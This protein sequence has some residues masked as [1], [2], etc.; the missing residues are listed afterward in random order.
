MELRAVDRR[1][2]HDRLRV[3]LAPLRLTDSLPGH[4]TVVVAQ[5]ISIFSS[6]RVTARTTS[7]TRRPPRIAPIQRRSS[8]LILVAIAFRRNPA[9]RCAEYL[10]ERIATSIKFASVT[11]RHGHD[12]DRRRRIPRST[13]SR[14]SGHRRSNRS[15]PSRCPPETSVRER[16]LARGTARHE[17][18]K[19]RWNLQRK[20]G[21]CLGVKPRGG[22]LPS[23]LKK[24]LVL[25][26]TAT[27]ES[28]G[29]TVGACVLPR[30]HSFRPLR[31]APGWT[32]ELP[33]G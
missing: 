33:A 2:A 5:R 20:Q 21:E 6:W 11:V 16:P 4:I 8:A 29:R 22:S 28:H 18:Q 12:R 23:E 26:T 3:R 10:Y 24:E 13:A 32:S 1:R 30:R 14:E 17:F 15:W 27:C 7:N 25:A 19:L 31:V 9:R